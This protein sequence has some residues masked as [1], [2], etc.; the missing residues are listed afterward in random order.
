MHS[1]TNEIT[2]FFMDRKTKAGPKTES[3]IIDLYRRGIINGETLCLSSQTDGQW[4]PYAQT[5]LPLNTFR[6]PPS[7]WN[8]LH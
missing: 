1:T 4:M 5:K 2:W 6:L 7:P 3:E 8:T